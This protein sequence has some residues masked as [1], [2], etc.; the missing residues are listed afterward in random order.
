MTATD[1]PPPPGFRPIPLAIGFIGAI[2]PLCVKLD[3][4]GLALGFRVET[5]HCN[6]MQICH[7]G[8]MAT[9][10]DML[11]PFVA[12]HQG[13][14]GGRFLPTVHLA[15]DFLA[16]A[17]LGSWVE[18]QGELLR[19]TKTL[20]FTRCS[21]TADGAPCA[22]GNGIFRLG[23]ETGGPGLSHFLEQMRDRD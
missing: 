10:I 23:P 5:R 13:N 17:P 3:D 18:G 1:L 20:V 6:P 16:P 9:F 22:T 4:S 14:L 11:M 19:A 12:I 2:G 7:G 8:M 15:Q 21:V